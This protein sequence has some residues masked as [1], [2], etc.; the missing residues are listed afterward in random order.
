[1][2]T[3]GF[4]SSQE[5]AHILGGLPHTED[6]QRFPQLKKKEK[7]RNHAFMH[8]FTAS[9]NQGMGQKRLFI[10]GP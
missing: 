3:Q 10:H 5:P 2:S 6:F 4:P 7:E 9:F 8:A 1:M